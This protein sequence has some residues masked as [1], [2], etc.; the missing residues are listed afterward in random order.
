MQ[1]ELE[2]SKV[3]FSGPVL[4]GTTKVLLTD[5]CLEIQTAP[6]HFESWRVAGELSVSVWRRAPERPHDPN[7][8][9]APV[10]LA[11]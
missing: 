8:A 2:L 11:A 3:Y 4:L 10:R 1:K 6:F 9:D 7:F 5:R